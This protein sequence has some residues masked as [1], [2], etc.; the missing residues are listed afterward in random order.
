MRFMIL[1][2]TG[3]VMACFSPTQAALEFTDGFEGTS[4]DPFWNADDNPFPA[5]SPA[6][7]EWSSYAFSSEQ[8]RSGNQSLKIV[9]QANPEGVTTFF[10]EH[11]FA[12]PVQ[13]KF[14]VW[15]YDTLDPIWG[16]LYLDRDVPYDLGETWASIG[17]VPFFDFSRPDYGDF[18]YYVDQLPG[19]KVKG[20]D[21]SL[22]WHHYEI[23]VTD[24]GSSYRLDGVDLGLINPLTNA[25]TL[26][27]M[28]QR[29][30]GIP[31]VFVTYF[32]D[33]S[34]TPIPEPATVFV[35]SVGAWVLLKHKRR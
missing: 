21:K 35:L 19:W 17:K 32:D 22:G 4:L 18:G 24:N 29:P 1:V 31:G 33:F 5:Y 12:A 34:F 8:V 26:L 7:S 14:S 13:G 9:Y 2:A 25:S 20:G 10:L 30:Y 6:C 3:L 23:T 11:L 16:G 28:T 27:L 15:F